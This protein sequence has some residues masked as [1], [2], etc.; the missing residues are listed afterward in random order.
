MDGGK[1]VMPTEDYIWKDLPTF[2]EMLYKKSKDK[3]LADVVSV[4]EKS[5]T[6]GKFAC[7]YA[8]ST[9]SHYV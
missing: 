3:S 5:H 8:S 1:P 9:S 6:K 2:N 4:F 7:Y